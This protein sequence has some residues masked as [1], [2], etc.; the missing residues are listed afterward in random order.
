[1]FLC[2]D[3][4]MQVNYNYV[5]AL[6]KKRIRIV[7]EVLEATLAYFPDEIESHVFHKEIAQT[8]ETFLLIDHCIE[9]GDAVEQPSVHRRFRSIGTSSFGSFKEEKQEEKIPP[10]PQPNPVSEPLLA[11][12]NAVGGAIDNVGNFIK[13]RLGEPK[14]PQSPG[15][16]TNLGINTSLK[17]PVVPYTRKSRRSFAVRR[18]DDLE[19]NEMGDGA[20][21]L[22]D[23]ERPPTELVP[24]YSYPLPTFGSPGS[25]LG[26]LLETNSFLFLAIFIA[27]AKFLDYAVKFSVTMDLDILLL[28]IWASFCIGLHTPRPMVGG[29]DKSA[30]PSNMTLAAPPD[31]RL[32]RQDR[33]GRELMVMSLRAST[34][35][36]NHHSVSLSVTPEA[37]PYQN[38]NMGVSEVEGMRNDDDGDES[39][40]GG[41]SPLPKFPEGAP[42]GSKHNCWSEPDYET[43]H[44]R[45][46]R[47]LSDKVKE[48]SGPFLFPIRAVDLFLTDTCPENAGRNAGILGG[49]LREKPTFIINF[50][51]PWGVF[52]AYFEI[53]ER[54][55]PFIRAGHE[56]GFDVSTVPS[57]ETMS[58]VDRCVA[59]FCQDSQTEKNKK[60]KIVPVVVEGPWIVKSV[61]GGKPAIIGNKMPVKYHYSPASSDGEDALYLE[62]D[63]DIVSSSAARG[64]LSVARTYTQ[65]LTIDLGFVVQGNTPDELPEQ[66]LVGARLHGIDPMTAPPYPLA[67]DMFSHQTDSDDSGGEE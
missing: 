49:R 1:M 59:R 12:Q 66:M 45:G 48:A 62:A 41:Q 28:F 23:D 46:S 29:I 58:P 7:N 30:A 67:S 44:V 51:L 2:L 39:V 27:A 33:H 65:V 11:V 16:D 35:T 14:R 10:L 56:E 26:D 50:R 43:F 61:V 5:K 13:D 53:P 9:E 18:S 21:L 4:S 17:S 55:I 19:L 60:L 52:L 3:S 37:E 24:S 6:S 31:S 22:L 63:L 34:P 36:S 32:R 25:R 47:Y 40:E 38:P 20:N 15:R 64:I 42:L 54:Y 57:M 8:I